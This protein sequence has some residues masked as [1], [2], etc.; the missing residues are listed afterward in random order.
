MSIE[1]N[2]TCGVK[3]TI[4]VVLRMTNGIMGFK[5]YQELEVVDMVSPWNIVGMVWQVLT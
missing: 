1:E 3:D 4:L 2:P 5:E